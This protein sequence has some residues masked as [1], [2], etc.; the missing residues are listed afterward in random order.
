[1]N[2]K[3]VLVVLLALSL[4]FP[5]QAFAKGLHFGIIEAIEEKI[6]ELQSKRY[7]TITNT[8][9]ALGQV[10]IHSDLLD[11][12]VYVT[13]ES[14]ETGQ[15]L[16]GIIVN[17]YT[18]KEVVILTA[19]D[20]DNRYFPTPYF[21]SLSSS[22]SE[23]GLP[24]PEQLS[25]DVIEIILKLPLVVEDIHIFAENLPSWSPDNII[26]F[27]G[28]VYIGTANFATIGSMLDVTGS[29]LGFVPGAQIVSAI[30]SLASV[31]I[32]IA[33]WLSVDIYR[34]FDWYWIPSLKLIFCLPRKEPCTGYLTLEAWRHEPPSDVALP[35]EERFYAAPSVYRWTLSEFK[36]SSDGGATWT[37]NLLTE[38]TVDFASV[39]IGEKVGE[40]ISDKALACDHYN[41]WTYTV[42]GL[43]VKGVVAVDPGQ[44]GGTW[45][46]GTTGIRYYYTNAAG[47]GDRYK[48]S[49]TD[50]QAAAEEF[51]PVSVTNPIREGSCDINISS[52]ETIISKYWLGCWLIYIARYGDDNKFTYG[53]WLFKDRSRLEF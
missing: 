21:G 4:L 40:F 36:L 20:P 51:G 7:E 53:S 48:D 17:F 43:V 47:K 23:T 11:K 50:A 6:G 2:K 39:E 32:K 18:D 1:M 41:R 26:R 52:N 27:P 30:T 19:L 25:I 24:H 44:W 46:D 38:P 35:G 49:P 42:S 28:I 22:S 10:I 12:D 29:V 31:S 14:A 9:D 15:P 37:E 3:I 8:T 45:E 16:S 5:H 13:T 33:G 34:E